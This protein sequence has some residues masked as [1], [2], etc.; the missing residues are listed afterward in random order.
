VA[1]EGRFVLSL[2]YRCD[3]PAGAVLTPADDVAEAE[4][5]PLA[6]L[7]DEIAFPANR[8]VLLALQ[9]SAA[10]PAGDGSPG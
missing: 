4:W 3:L 5:F 10:I 8:R 2:F 1:A 9:K 7:P 6:A